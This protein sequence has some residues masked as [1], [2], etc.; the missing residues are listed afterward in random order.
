MLLCL[1]RAL[2]APVRSATLAPRAVLDG[3]RLLARCQ[4]HTAARDPC[5]LLCSGFMPQHE[6]V[7]RARLARYALQPLV[8]RRFPLAARGE[9]EPRLE[10]LVFPHWTR[11]TLR[12]RLT[13]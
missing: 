1:L 10:G 13:R 3:S 8:T 12:F 2:G 7:R 5:S 4:R 11:H 6:R 9:A